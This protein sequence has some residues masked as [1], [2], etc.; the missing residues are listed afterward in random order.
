[1]ERGRLIIQHDVIR[2]GHTHD[3]GHPC[4]R[5]QRQQVV[6]VVLIGLGMVGIADVDA[7]RQTS[8]L[9]QK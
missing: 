1:M 6:H 2:S 7:E 4:G 8:S 9:P 3:K 5:K